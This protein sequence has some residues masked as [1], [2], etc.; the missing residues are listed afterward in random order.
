MTSYCQVLLTTLDISTYYYYPMLLLC[1][2]SISREVHS[3]GQYKSNTE[4]TK[5]YYSKKTKKVRKSWAKTRP[6]NMGRDKSSLKTPHKKGQKK[7]IAQYTPAKNLQGQLRRALVCTQKGL[8]KMCLQWAKRN[9]L[10]FCWGGA[11][12][13]VKYAKCACF[14]RKYIS[15][16]IYV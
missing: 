10:F 12:C 5:N 15:I 13:H 7:T 4:T 11:M 14:D 1:F 2:Y 9:A 8:I 3:C 6:K 16:Y